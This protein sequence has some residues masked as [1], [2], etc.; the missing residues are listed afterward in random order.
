[1]IIWLSLTIRSSWL[2]AEVTFS[3]YHLGVTNEEWWSLFFSAS[4]LPLSY[5]LQRWLTNSQVLKAYFQVTAV[6]G[7]KTEK[8]SVL[9]KDSLARHLQQARMDFTGIL[10]PGNKSQGLSW[11]PE[12]A[13]K[14]SNN[15]REAGGLFIQMCWQKKA[16]IKDTIE[17]KLQAD[18]EYS[19]H[20]GV[21]G[22]QLFLSGR[23]LL[24]EMVFR[25]WA[26]L[27]QH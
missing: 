25:N 8:K 17:N 11:R 5:C 16:L 3:S 4:L 26:E 27:C 15:K 22:I 9:S 20:E 10:I 24:G 6:S 21:K 23:R 13:S 7:L 18:R 19:E 2:L 12:A 14:N 1:M